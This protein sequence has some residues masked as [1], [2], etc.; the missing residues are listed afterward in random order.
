MYSINHLHY[1]TI[2]QCPVSIQTWGGNCQLQEANEIYSEDAETILLY[3]PANQE[4]DWK[5]AYVDKCLS[6]NLTAVW[7]VAFMEAAEKKRLL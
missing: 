5:S 3:S 2:A 7:K 4:G 1:S 6:N